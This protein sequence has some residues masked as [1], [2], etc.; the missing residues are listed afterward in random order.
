MT[1]TST[2]AR[3]ATSSAPPGGGSGGT[4]QGGGNLSATWQGLAQ[5][6]QML[7]DVKAGI[8][9]LRALISTPAAAMASGSPAA[10]A[11]IVALGAELV[12]FLAQTVEAIDSDI[13]AM[14][15]T[16]QTYQQHE[17]E[18]TTSATTGMTALTGLSGATS[19]A[20]DRNAGVQSC[21][22]R[23]AMQGYSYLDDV[24]VPI[25]AG[26]RTVGN[27]T[28]SVLGAGERL[29][30]GAG[31]VLG[32]MADNLTYQPGVGFV[33]NFSGGRSVAGDAIRA[34]SNVSAG[35]LRGASDAVEDVENRYA[36]GA[37][38]AR[39]ISQRADELLTLE[40]SCTT[41]TTPRVARPSVP[42]RST[43]R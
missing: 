18:I 29:V 7:G 39:V 8:L 26:V 40:G 32:S 2:L 9:T 33:P 22:A 5:I 41:P 20:L 14:T 25:A 15:K 37:A 38:R 24:A 21:V 43:S 17:N 4:S 31:S 28:Q 35:V 10:G 16:Q 12:M 36:A 6:P 30:T 11:A 34:S 23:G 42:I 1:G 27:A 13:E 3:T 19:P